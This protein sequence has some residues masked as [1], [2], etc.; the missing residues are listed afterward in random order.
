MYRYYIRIAQPGGL[1]IFNVKCLT[2]TVV[3]VLTV[4]S[5][6]SL[7]FEDRSGT[8]VVVTSF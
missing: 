5:G 3:E 4:V 8:F 2:F 7:D 6:I 1:A